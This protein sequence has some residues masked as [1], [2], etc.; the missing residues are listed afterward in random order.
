Y[1]YTELMRMNSSAL[2]SLLDEDRSRH[3]EAIN[4]AIEQG[5]NIN[6]VQ[7]HDYEA[8][9][10]KTAK[11]LLQRQAI[12]RRTEKIKPVTYLE[13]ITFS[14][15][16][17]NEMVE[18]EIYREIRMILESIGKS[19]ED[20]QNENILLSDG[21]Y[22]IFELYSQYGAVLNANGIQ[23]VKGENGKVVV[24]TRGIV[25]HCGR[26]SGQVWINTDDLAMKREELRKIL[27]EDTDPISEAKLESLAIDALTRHLETERDELLDQTKKELNLLGKTPKE[28]IDAIRTL[29]DNKAQ[30][31]R[32]DAHNAAVA[33]EKEFIE[34]QIEAQKRAVKLAGSRAAD[35]KEKLKSRG[36]RAPDDVAE[37]FD[38][39]ITS[40]HKIFPRIKRWWRKTISRSEFVTG[41]KK[42]F[43]KTAEKKE[44][45]RKNLTKKVS[46]EI[47][48]IEST[49]E[50]MS[51]GTN[52]IHTAVIDEMKKKVDK[53]IAQTEKKIRIIRNALN[54]KL[55]EI[56]R[57]KRKN[58][59]GTTCEEG[60]KTNMET[61][62]AELDK[63]LAIWKEISSDRKKIALLSLIRQNDAVLREMVKQN[64]FDTQ[65]F[66]ILSAANV[67]LTMKLRKGMVLRE[68]QIEAVEYTIQGF[69]L[70]LE[71][72]QGK[73]FVALYD[74]YLASLKWE[75]NPVDIMAKEDKESKKLAYELGMQF[76]ML[77][78]GYDFISAEQDMDYDGKI[79]DFYME[80]G[81]LD[82]AAKEKELLKR[83]QK[84]SLANIRFV[85]H[86][87]VFALLH[88]IRI[89]KKKIKDRYL[90]KG[91]YDILID[92]SDSLVLDQALSEFIIAVREGRLSP[93]LALPYYIACSMAALLQKNTEKTMLKTT[94]DEKLDELKSE[95]DE[96]KE[97]P[98]VW[99]ILNE[100]T[101]KPT[102]TKEGKNAVDKIVSEAEEKILTN[103][104][105]KYTTSTRPDWKKLVQDSLNVRFREGQAYW[106]VNP[107]TGKREAR[108]LA[109]GLDAQGRKWQ[110]GQDE[111]VQILMG[112]Y[113]ISGPGKTQSKMSM[114]E[115]LDMVYEGR[116]TGLSG[117][118]IEAQDEY[119]ENYGGKQVEKAA[120][121]E[122]GSLK[123]KKD[124]TVLK[125]QKFKQ[126]ILEFCRLRQDEYLSGIPVVLM[127]GEYHRH[128][129][130]VE[131]VELILK[132]AK[133]EVYID[134]DIAPTQ[135]LD[136]EGIQEVIKTYIDLT[137]DDIEVLLNQDMQKF[138]TVS[139][140]NEAEKKN[141][142]A[143]A[144]R[145]GY[146]SIIPS[147]MGGR[148]SDYGVEGL[149]EIYKDVLKTFSGISEND[150]IKKA[151]CTVL[152]KKTKDNI[153]GVD[154]FG[155]EYNYAREILKQA[156][157]LNEV[158]SIQEI[159]AE[160]GDV[161]NEN[162]LRD[163]AGRNIARE[164]LENRLKTEETGLF[165][166]LTNK[167]MGENDVD[168]AFFIQDLAQK[169][170]LR[171][172][173]NYGIQFIKEKDK[174]ERVEVQSDGRAARVGM[175][176]GV[177]NIGEASGDE[178]TTDTQMVSDAFSARDTFRWYSMGDWAFRLTYK[179][180]LK[181]LEKLEKKRKTAIG[182]QKYKE[183]DELTEKIK[184]LEK[185]LAN[186]VS[187]RGTLAYFGEINRRLQD[188]D[189]NRANSEENAKKE[190]LEKE[191]NLY[192]TA[193]QKRNERR[194]AKIRKFRNLRNTLPY[195]SNF[196]HLSR[197][198]SDNKTLRARITK[199]IVKFHIKEI[200]KGAFP[201][202]IKVY[203]KNPEERKNAYTEL[204]R[205]IHA[206]YDETLD[207]DYLS[208]LLE[209][210]V[211]NK[212]RPS[213]KDIEKVLT[214]IFTKGVEAGKI[215]PEEATITNILSGVIEKFLEEE[216]LVLTSSVRWW[217]VT[218][219]RRSLRQY[220]NGWFFAKKRVAKNA[221][222]ID[223]A[224]QL[225]KYDE[226][227][228]AQKLEDEASK[229]NTTSF[230]LA[231]QAQKSVEEMIL[232]TMK[233]PKMGHDQESR[234]KPVTTPSERK[235]QKDKKLRVRRESVFGPAASR[236]KQIQEA[237]ATTTALEK[238][239]E[240]TRRVDPSFAREFKADGK[241][242][243]KEQK[244]VTSEIEENTA[245]LESEKQKR[246]KDFTEKEDASKKATTSESITLMDNS[247]LDVQIS[248]LPEGK[249]AG[250]G[251][252]ART[253]SASPSPTGTPP[254]DT[255]IFCG[256]AGA[257]F[258]SRREEEKDSLRKEA[259]EL[260]NNVPKP[261]D[262]CRV[263][264]IEDVSQVKSLT[265]SGE[266]IEFYTKHGVMVLS[267]RT[268]SQ[269]ALAWKEAQDGALYDASSLDKKL[270][271]ILLQSQAEFVNGFGAN[272]FCVPSKE[273]KQ[274]DGTITSW[275][276]YEV[277]DEN[278]PDE[279][280]ERFISALSLISKEGTAAFRDHE[281]NTKLLVKPDVPD[282]LLRT[283]KWRYFKRKREKEKMQKTFEEGQ[284]RPDMNIILKNPFFRALIY[285]KENMPIKFRE[286]G[287][288]LIGTQLLTK[289]NFRQKT[290][291][292]FPSE[293]FF[294]RSLPRI[295]ERF[296]QWLAE[297]HLFWGIIVGIAFFAFKGIFYDLPKHVKTFVW[298]KGLRRWFLE[299]PETND[300][301]IKK[302]YD[303]VSFGLDA[304]TPKEIPPAIAKK[305]GIVLT[306]REENEIELNVLA[307]AEIISKKAMR[308][309]SPSRRER[310]L[311]EARRIAMY[312]Y[313]RTKDTA[314]ATILINIL[315]EMKNYDDVIHYGKKIIR[316]ADK[317]NRYRLTWT[318]PP[319]YQDILAALYEAYTQK[320]NMW[321]RT[322]IRRKMDK[323]TL[324]KAVS[325]SIRT[326]KKPE[327]E[328]KPDTGKG[329]KGLYEKS[330]LVKPIVDFYKKQKFVTKSLITSPLYVLVWAFG[331]KT[332]LISTPMIIAAIFILDVVIAPIVV[333][334]YK[335]NAA[336]RD[337]KRLVSESPGDAE[338][339]I[340][341]IELFFGSPDDFDTKYAKKLLNKLE[342]S[343]RLTGRSWFLRGLFFIR[344]SF[345]YSSNR[346]NDTLDLT[347]Y[348]LIR[349]SDAE[350]GREKAEKLLK[351]AEKH[352][353]T[354][355]ST[356][357]DLLKA[358][359]E[360]KKGE[361]DIL[362]HGKSVPDIT[363]KIDV[364]G[365]SPLEILFL[366]GMVL[367]NTAAED[368]DDSKLKKVINEVKAR[369][370]RLLPQEGT[371]T[372][373]DKKLL[374]STDDM[375]GI[376]ALLGA[377]AYP[378]RYQ[379]KYSDLSRMLNRLLRE[380]T[381]EAQKNKEKTADDAYQN[382]KKLRR[383]TLDE[384]E[385]TIRD[386]EKEKE[387]DRQEKPEE[388][389][390][391][392]RIKTCIR[393]LK[394]I[395]GDIEEKKIE[396]RLIGDYISLANLYAEKHEKTSLWKKF[397][398]KITFISFKT[399]ETRA[400]KNAIRI[401]L[402][403]SN[404]ELQFLAEMKLL[405]VSI[406]KWHFKKVSWLIA[407]IN[408]L[409]PLIKSLH[410]K[411]RNE[412]IS[413]SEKETLSL[414][415]ANLHKMTK[416]LLE[417][418]K[419]RDLYHERA[420][421]IRTL[422]ETDLM[423]IEDT[424]EIKTLIASKSDK[425]LS[426]RKGPWRRKGEIRVELWQI[427]R[428][429][430]GLE[431]DLERKQDQRKESIEQKKDTTSI[432]AEIVQL[433]TEMSALNDQIAE[434]YFQNLKLRAESVD[435]ID[436]NPELVWNFVLNE[437]KPDIDAYLQRE[438]ETERIYE[439]SY[440]VFKSEMETKLGS[441]IPP[442][443][444]SAI[445]YLFVLGWMKTNQRQF[446]DI[447]LKNLNEKKDAIDI[448]KPPAEIQSGKIKHT[449]NEDDIISKIVLEEKRELNSA[450]F[451]SAF[452]TY[453]VLLL[454]P[455]LS[456]KYKTWIT[457]QL[458]S[459]VNRTVQSDEIRSIEAILNKIS[460][461][462]LVLR[463]KL[464]LLKRIYVEPALK[465]MCKAKK[466]TLD[467]VTS[468]VEQYVNGLLFLIEKS[469]D[470]D[471]ISNA[472]N[473]FFDILPRLPTTE[474]EKF[475]KALLAL[476][477]PDNFESF[478]YAVSQLL[479]I[480][481]SFEAKKN[482]LIAVF[483]L[484]KQSDDTKI[485]EKAKSFASA[486]FKTD[487]KGKTTSFSEFIMY[488]IQTYP[489]FDY[490]K[491]LS[492]SRFIS[493]FI[494]LREEA[495]SLGRAENFENLK[496]IA[497]VLS[498]NNVTNKLAAL[499]REPDISLPEQDRFLSELHNLYFTINKAQ[500]K[501]KQ[502][503]KLSLAP[504]ETALLDVRQQ[505]EEESRQKAWAILSDAGD[506][507][508]LEADAK[509]TGRDNEGA[510]SN[511]SKAIEKFKQ[512]I[513]EGRRSGYITDRGEGIFVKYVNDQIIRA[514]LL[515]VRCLLLQGKQ[516]EATKKEHEM[517]LWAHAN[518]NT[519]QNDPGDELRAA[520]M[521]LDQ[522]KRAEPENAKGSKE[523]GD[524]RLS[525]Y[526]NARNKA[527][528]KREKREKDIEKK[529][530]LEKTITEKQSKISNLKTTLKGKES[531]VKDIESRLRSL[532]MNKDVFTLSQYLGHRKAIFFELRD[533]QKEL[534]TQKNTLEETENEIKKLEAE[535][536][537]VAEQLDKGEKEFLELERMETF[538]DKKAEE[539]INFGETFDNS[540]QRS[541]DDYILALSQANDKENDIA[542]EVEKE[543]LFLAEDSIRARYVLDEISR[544]LN[545]LRDDE[546][547]VKKGALKEKRFKIVGIKICEN[548]LKTDDLTGRKKL[549]SIFMASLTSQN[550]DITSY[551]ALDRLTLFEYLTETDDPLTLQ[552]LL[553]TSKKLPKTLV[554]TLAL[555][556]LVN[557]MY[558]TL[559]I[560]SEDVFPENP[561]ILDAFAEKE[562][563][564][565][566]AFQG[567]E[568]MAKEEK[569]LSPIQKTAKIL[570]EL[571]TL[572]TSLAAIADLQTTLTAIKNEHDTDK[573]WEKMSE[574]EQKEFIIDLVNTDVSV[575]E[576]LKLENAAI[577]NPAE[578]IRQNAD[579]E[580]NANKYR[581]AE[582]LYDEAKD[583]GIDDAKIHYYRG[584][585]YESRKLFTKATEEYEKV[586]EKGEEKDEPIIAD[587]YA[588]LVKLYQLFNKFSELRKV[589]E[590]RAQKLL[591]RFTLL[592]SPTSLSFP[593]TR[594]SLSQND[595]DI[596]N[597]A[598]TAVNKS[599]N[600][601]PNHGPALILKAKIL[602]ALGRRDDALILV[603][604]ILL[605]TD[606]NR[607]KRFFLEAFNPMRKWRV[608]KATEAGKEAHL[609]RAKIYE[610][611]N[612]YPKANKDVNIAIKLG[613]TSSDAYLIKAKTEDPFHT[614]RVFQIW[615]AMIACLMFAPLVM[616]VGIA[617]FFSQA[618]ISPI[619]ISAYG[620]N[621]AGVMFLGIV[622]PIVAELL[623]WYRKTPYFAEQKEYLIKAID[624]DSKNFEAKELLY[625]LLFEREDH[626]EI[627]SE[628]KKE[629]EALKKDR[630]QKARVQ[631][632]K[633]R[634][635]LA[636][637]D[638]QKQIFSLLRAWKQNEKALAQ[639]NSDIKEAKKIDEIL[640]ADGNPLTNTQAEFESLKQRALKLIR[641]R[642]FLRTIL[643]KIL[644]VF[645][646]YR[647]A[648]K[649]ALYRYLLLSAQFSGDRPGT[650]AALEKL[651]NAS[652]VAASTREEAGKELSEN[653][654]LRAQTE[655][656]TNFIL[657]LLARALYYDPHNAKARL[658]RG[659]AMPHDTFAEK[660]ITKALQEEPTLRETEE[661]RD[662]Y[663]ILAD[664]YFKDGNYD[665]WLDARNKSLKKWQVD[666]TLSA[667]T[668]LNANLD[669]KARGFIDNDKL[670]N[671]WAETK[672]EVEK[673]NRNLKKHFQAGKSSDEQSNMYKA[674]KE[675]LDTI[676]LVSP[677]VTGGVDANSIELMR[678]IIFLARRNK[679]ETTILTEILKLT[680]NLEI[681]AR[682]HFA[683]AEIYKK[684][685]KTD[686]AWE[687]I[688]ALTDTLR[689][690]LP[691]YEKSQVL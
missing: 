662:A 456:P 301:L 413:E 447:Q 56:M 594:E 326:A 343:L 121:F 589:H 407:N 86:H 402:E 578:K 440:D 509:Y 504:I 472:K 506:A 239:E 625:E 542:V 310:L 655:T 7:T 379:E 137:E 76:N 521:V 293:D 167:Y 2:Q 307:L 468:H 537:E 376:D 317:E 96:I 352:F 653:L 138:R 490:T 372:D 530:E 358:L 149:G 55:P 309:A 434:M 514:Y 668:K 354:Y 19:D 296:Q 255:I 385:V 1:H 16:E 461:T 22:N 349:F 564:S 657:F 222:K 204:K 242:E 404:D 664:C 446:N 196:F 54:V 153:S 445:L 85:S 531:T 454:D 364:I 538:E 285:S 497:H 263:L 485:F 51:T 483:N 230:D 325:K 586:L 416:L 37:Q 353:T 288:V 510:V 421:T 683:L 387:K 679:R 197:E 482:I 519:L 212:R 464:R 299:K 311:E 66:R 572:K 210:E 366:L 660:D 687:Q 592:S 624:A 641:I 173:A 428:K 33:A 98:G 341:L 214:G 477:T 553:E 143:T 431:T 61:E 275:G 192:L 194:H 646:I 219:W 451:S 225:K 556:K 159:I 577:T 670:W 605:R 292:S 29:P 500:K 554:G 410:A 363:K 496:I 281:K 517:H 560:A 298:E 552:L 507:F 374:D 441:A 370:N 217:R 264:I 278:M 15:R 258:E 254:E 119:S 215:L 427:E 185:K 565:I 536:N 550:I 308:S 617:Y 247:S 28:T 654:R 21:T 161:S 135:W 279:G 383:E 80:N 480:N 237:P 488:L 253:L 115:L 672:K 628:C 306:T 606:M 199:L 177:I 313:V 658:A 476:I 183:A 355:T 91:F 576:P 470:A 419:A 178:T 103:M 59:L 5:A 481:E 129:K 68:H 466:D 189:E 525:S 526:K 380:E 195:Q 163:N 95:D 174:N 146:L 166:T 444:K 348:Y 671:E 648:N 455:D 516:D 240:D 232:N 323:G 612:V 94:Y 6:L 274:D 337:K 634:H 32:K 144:G 186:D 544:V 303:P 493:V 406:G 593:R 631:E 81:E 515:T 591:D 533:A 666:A 238:E 62:L 491:P 585:I 682:V 566:V 438:Q 209:R 184:S 41:A 527:K 191:W 335:K 158:E 656:D 13:T 559:S 46:K 227:L 368:R 92:E 152:N 371:V 295:G 633:R 378:E 26:V 302:Y 534:T 618:W 686:K 621:F 395:D 523:R 229:K 180:R 241:V 77:G 334:W 106:G 31:V 430:L 442:N 206:V 259:A 117:T 273:E 130:F 597:A 147:D 498:D 170:I 381:D 458:L 346:L 248:V 630:T 168:L 644:F 132:L 636:L 667:E 290:A 131:Q 436:S 123:H 557:R 649:Q 342:A 432:D 75:G 581:E 401:S 72:G 333:K 39:N 71:T 339:R 502:R 104:G 623:S 283:P 150:L 50:I 601:I 645:R 57:L 580:Y 508:Y 9:L 567:K 252:F 570:R 24:I 162:N 681:E 541:M 314:A 373:G 234:R 579:V 260:L 331:L 208:A 102:L 249:T 408:A 425:D 142:E 418:R 391:K 674:F 175:P 522:A 216:R 112:N 235:Y 555:W 63:E 604:E 467:T 639:L 126:T 324:Q 181:K 602:N 369:R 145:L 663:K 473:D 362:I 549:I 65:E 160:L 494:L 389:E 629:E 676:T 111:A 486:F 595:T 25:S 575:S 304:T 642:I 690:L 40:Y 492:V 83:R 272:F 689:N 684:A 647:N 367:K 188:I 133:G 465:D 392:A 435:S 262:S 109:E 101:N 257:Y 433:K 265:E 400:L 462:P 459:I 88:D 344:P 164:N 399:K 8:N 211:F 267:K 118:N 429:L 113:E 182:E 327:E 588:R 643:D 563:E 18:R 213:K 82:K 651:W 97:V 673:L 193:A 524:L 105:F 328:E 469:D 356:R 44:E 139:A 251:L 688:N 136:E 244:H 266:N 329:I 678:R 503:P 685:G 361:K 236:E 256:K 74:R 635:A 48:V 155:E 412:T 665:A 439:T 626:D 226:A 340:K 669:K 478:S 607:V 200:V 420:A 228:A 218:M 520:E 568:K 322:S 291:L 675:R 548:L 202:S 487:F 53:T 14:H 650:T 271:G 474:K 437:L 70:N 110:D 613:E 36:T 203:R 246:E 122:K 596:L 450:G 499:V 513:E 100:E 207:L 415:L 270:N 107:E 397:W 125:G 250:P 562:A 338:T 140:D 34:T 300:E 124:V 616:S 35:L 680:T 603:N 276:I 661:G 27:S 535:K 652:D 637:L 127:R 529:A 312:F 60:Y 396:E 495:E 359:L 52:S 543:L 620:N 443:L 315:L 453:I 198:I 294:E 11:T 157:I 43:A 330:Y 176:G 336:R 615:A 233:I 600:V 561:A 318:L 457:E 574:K 23:L 599:L 277:S 289:N 169:I 424:E 190:I 99:V 573:P 73:T 151:I 357:Y 171:Y 224:R 297:I 120:T 614:G 141:V 528:E 609:L 640:A 608:F 69:I 390:L 45:E 571:E 42:I 90:L 423:E 87:I 350:K 319:K 409:L 154:K 610:A 677:F 540:F 282:V 148:A 20:L 3:K 511:A 223:V 351:F 49:A 269:M 345:F 417:T 30:K 179:W 12:L 398:R 114:K 93:H 201:K 316:S 691:E 403:A 384:K 268:A 321:K 394:S 382:D 67:S 377:P 78:R 172:D 569:E 590:T 489:A 558:K 512:I 611:D 479:K 659:C 414:A 505:I 484:A 332:A 17:L 231:L 116:W 187:Y 518:V 598:L 64:E 622:I 286:D 393:E 460:D 426:L 405:E 360:L 47:D 4:K 584:R 547:D 261:T 320:G 386:E 305:L 619:I 551:F 243:K 245:K 546:K 375:L 471:V 448:K 347:E 582:K 220:G 463:I 449:R 411:D 388:K 38:Q 638:K 128:K 532:R 501:A 134:D 156:G 79:L 365:N 221:A 165:H 539:E 280:Y 583:A 284:K 287:S 10:R 205:R 587:A 627:I 632:P 58:N 545:S 422:L 475:T 452:K 89:G 108:L 84:A